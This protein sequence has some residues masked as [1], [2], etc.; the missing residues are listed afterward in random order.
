MV[1]S[2]RRMSFWIV[3]GVLV[4]AC[5]GDTI[6][7]P[8]FELP[9]MQPNNAL[10]QCQVSSLTNF[11]AAFPCYGAFRIHGDQDS[12][13]ING[14]MDKW[15]DALGSEATQ[16]VPQFTWKN[17][18]S[19]ANVK[20]RFLTTT[21][22]N[23]VCGDVFP[24]GSIGD[25]DSVVINIKLE[26]TC[27]NPDFLS[28]LLVHEMGHM[29]GF[30]GTGS[31]TLGDPGYSDH[32]ASYLPASG[33][34]DEICQ[35]DI[36]YIYLAYSQRQGGYDPNNFWDRHV[37]T[38]IDT[39]SGPVSVRVDETYQIQGGTN[40]LFNLGQP[41]PTPLGQTTVS[42]TVTTGKASVNA[43]TGLLMGEFEGADTAKAAVTPPTSLYINSTELT[44][45]KQRVPIDVLGCV[46]LRPLSIVVEQEPSVT[47]QDTLWFKVPEFV[48]CAVPV[49]W[50]WT[51]DPSNP[52][53]SDSTMLNVEDSVEFFVQGGSY[54]LTVTA[55]PH[56]PSD[57][58]IALIRGVN[59]CTELQLQIPGG[60]GGPNRPS[61]C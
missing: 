50:D 36:E 48:G 42:W 12:A 44:E 41:G 32:C 57:T 30:K 55:H 10:G 54:T 11:E 56:A 34:N 29:L 35:H 5:S 15:S 40:L 2:L 47:Y 61:G 43:T 26:S 37:V 7:D 19:S 23:K 38:G 21:T 9:D 24:Y 31:H 53:L 52:L 59:V 17:N 3:A 22:T 51:F 39:E 33:V 4:W 6:S 28:R 18:Y 25:R 14:A 45:L 46:P 8:G 58:G 1:R 49:S 20:I 60:G 27:T 16:G 13:I